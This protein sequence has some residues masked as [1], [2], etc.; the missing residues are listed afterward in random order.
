VRSVG[1]TWYPFTKVNKSPSPELLAS[2]IGVRGAATEIDQSGVRSGAV[3]NITR[4]PPFDLDPT[5]LDR[6]ASDV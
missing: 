1:H 2:M 6:R 3:R 5:Y 4:I